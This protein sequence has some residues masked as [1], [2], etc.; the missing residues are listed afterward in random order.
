MQCGKNC[1]ILPY[2]AQFEN[3]CIVTKACAVPLAKTVAEFLYLPQ[4]CNQDDEVYNIL[5]SSFPTF[6]SSRTLK[7]IYRYV[8]CAGHMTSKYVEYVE[9]NSVWR[10]VGLWE[11]SA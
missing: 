2:Q 3:Q 4:L 9:R 11:E 10:N 5:L 8:F 6:C 7:C 1:N